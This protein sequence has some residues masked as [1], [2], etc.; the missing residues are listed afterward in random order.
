MATRPLPRSRS[1]P[2]LRVVRGSGKRKRSP[3]PIVILAILVV[4]GVTAIHA[5]IG[6]DGLKAAK[7]ERAVTQQ[8]DQH[9]LLRAQVAQLSSPARID[10]EAQHMGLVEVPNPRFLRVDP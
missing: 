4:F 5:V 6:Q 9:T 8:S 10:D 2:E 3:V 7:L 1:T